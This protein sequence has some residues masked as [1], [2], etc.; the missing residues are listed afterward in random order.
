MK[1]RDENEGELWDLYD[2]DRQLTG[3]THRRGEPMKA[4]DFHMV[5]HVCIFNS[6]NEMLIQQRQPFKKGWSN[7]WDVTTGGS[8]LKGDTSQKAAEREVFEEIGLKIDLTG[9]RPHFTINFN[10][11]FDDWYL[12]RQEVDISQ[13]KL[14][15]SEV[16]R[17]KWAGKEE[18]LGMCEEGI[19]IPVYFMKQLFEIQGNYG[20]LGA[21]EEKLEF[22]YVKWEN[23]SSWQSLNEILKCN[24]SDFIAPEENLMRECIQKESAVC[25]LSGKRVVGV[26]LYSKESKEPIHV[27]I[28]PEFPERKIQDGMSNL[29]Q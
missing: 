26:L 14:Q 19:M 17:V 23:W 20:S 5:V 29:I 16:Q 8:A 12:I 22:Q 3:R 4:E 18:V 21:Q 11:G 24:L 27:A 9:I 25:A 28:H 7:M 13:L 2:A 1:L 15:N 10:D 6:K